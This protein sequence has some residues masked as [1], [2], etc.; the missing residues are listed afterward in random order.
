MNDKKI[1]C[2]SMWKSIHIDIDG[3]LTPCCLFVHKIDKQKNITE[4]ANVESYLKTHHQKWRDQFNKGVWPDGCNQCKFAEEEGRESKRLQ[5]VVDYEHLNSELEEVS[6]EYLQ[7]KTGR[8]CNL[9]CTICS[10]ICST[11]SA[12]H[13]LKN[14]TLSKEDYDKLE[15]SSKWAEDIN[16]YKKI[17]ST[18]GFFRIDIAGGEPL[19]NKTHF[20]WLD[21]LSNK[22]LF[23]LY[24]TNGTIIPTE[25]EISI[26]EKFKGIRLT[27][28]VDSYEEKF[29]KLR[30][31]GTWIRLVKTFNFLKNMIN[32]RFNIDTSNISIV[33]TLYKANVMDI[34][35]LY[36]KLN[37]YLNA[38]ITESINF[39]YLYYPERKAI[40]NLSKEELTN[41]INS[42][43]SNLY[44]LRDNSRILYDTK[45]LISS[46]KTFLVDKKFS[47]PRPVT[48]TFN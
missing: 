16:Q 44:R 42:L 1:Y 25:E 40:H 26:W 12:V 28:S 3:Y 10:P 18:N 19:L 27:V 22:N 4:V 37:E 41:V 43:E 24:N 32:T 23:L 21:S 29:E 38:D 8:V 11:T 35:D 17:N 47:N 6:L 46:M 45:T 31:G 2:M 20:K 7:I 48:D 33:L 34:I 13:Q 5:D 36:E 9:R 15:L 30:I 14:G 39:N